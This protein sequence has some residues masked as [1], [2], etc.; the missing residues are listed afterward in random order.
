M[1][2]RYGDGLPIIGTFERDSQLA[3]NGERLTL[4]DGEGRILSQFVYSD[5]KAWPQEADG[6][7]HALVNKAPNSDAD[8]EEP[9][10]WTQSSQVGGSPGKAESNGPPVISQGYASWRERS[11]SAGAGDPM[12]DPLSDPDKDHLPNL[13]EYLFDQDPTVASPMIFRVNR[14]TVDGEDFIEVHYASATEVSDVTLTPEV[15]VNLVDWNSDGVDVTAVGEETVA[16]FPASGDN[17]QA[18]YFRLRAG[19]KP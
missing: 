17:S 14:I 18:A 13:L 11:F 3:N 4:V 7:G 19:L 12:A 15:S 6:N 2:M 1:E 8:L 9:S 10:A 5:G 16:R